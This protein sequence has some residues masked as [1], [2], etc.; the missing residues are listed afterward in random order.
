MSLLG[1]TISGKTEQISQLNAYI[2]P[3]IGEREDIFV[4]SC[5]TLD[6]ILNFKSLICK[7]KCNESYDILVTS[8]D[9]S[10]SSTNTFPGIA[11][12]D[13]KKKVINCS[14]FSYNNLKYNFPNFPPEIPDILIDSNFQLT[15]CPNKKG[16]FS[17]TGLTRVNKEFTYEPIGKISLAF[18]NL[19]TRAIV[20]IN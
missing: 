7:N 20:K 12:Y 13:L 19:Y 9:I 17:V 6:L 1:K 14:I 3:N 4:S 15:E 8:I 10:K 11:T 5:D 18:N 16:S 2:I